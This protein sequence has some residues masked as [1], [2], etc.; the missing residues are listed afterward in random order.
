MATQI[1]TQDRKHSRGFQHFASHR[2]SALAVVGA[3]LLVLLTAIRAGL[4]AK[5]FGEADHG[6][7]ALLATFASGVLFDLATLSY[8]LAPAA[9]YL[10]AVPQRVFRARWHRLLLVGIGTCLAG[11]FVFDAV[12]E[13]VFWDEF[14]VRFNF[15]AVDYLVYTH[16]V[17]GNIVES[18]PLGLILSAVAGVTIFLTW[19]VCRSTWY[20]LWSQG[21]TPPAGRWRWAA[22]PLVLA[23]AAGFCLTRD[24]TSGLTNRYNRELAGNGPYWFVAAFQGNS[25]DYDHFYRRIPRREAFTRLRTLIDTPNAAFVSSDPMTIRRRIENP[26]PEQRWNVIQITVESLSAS[27]LG[28]FGSRHNMTPNLD[29]LSGESLFFTNVFATGTRTVRGMEALTLSVPPTPGRSIVKRRGNGGLFSTGSLFRERGYDVRFIY[30]GYG[31]FDNMNAFFSKNGFDIIDR[32]SGHEAPV[33]F[34]NIWGACDQDLYTWVTEAADK[35]WA[36]GKPFYHFVMTTSNH[37]PYT[38]PEGT[39]DAPQGHRK[40]AALYTDYALAEFLEAASRR[41]WFAKTLFVITADHCMSS[42]GETDLPVRNYHIPLFV[43]APALIEPRIIDILCSQIDVAPTLLGL[44]NWTYDSEFYGRDVLRND[45]S[46]GRALVGNYQDL[47]YLRDGVLTVLKPMEK[48]E[49]FTCDPVSFVEA[50][51]PV[52]GDLARDTVAYYETASYLFRRHRERA[53][54]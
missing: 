29:R 5:C 26:G 44:M 51:T 4:L 7:G 11:G 45:G 32:A 1:T 20:R 38:F 24:I 18:Y 16:E 13:W 28:V 19:M 9:L 6:A 36:E 23:A 21:D 12:A 27:Y 14:G 30:S 50:E 34:A 31:Y 47:G 33:S 35:A 37:R 52:L 53:S 3:V 8:I 42:A 54:Q 43:Y 15:I 46:C 22:V 39:V 10:A 25:L 49:A 48:V 40:S 2:L 41:P 17:I